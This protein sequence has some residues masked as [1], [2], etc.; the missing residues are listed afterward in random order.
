MNKLI[1][2]G[3]GFDI[4]NGL[5]SK[6]IDFLT[7]YLT[8]CFDSSLN[9]RGNFKELINISANLINQGQNLLKVT[10]CKELAVWLINERNF[11]NRIYSPHFLYKEAMYQFKI[12]TTNSDLFTH[13]LDHQYERNWVDIEMTYYNLLKN[14]LSQF[15]LDGSE[16]KAT[17]EKKLSKINADFEIL[18]QNLHQYLAIISKNASADYNF[19]YSAESTIDSQILID[20]HHI[21][22]IPK[23]DFEDDRYIK[24]KDVTFLNFNYTGLPRSLKGKIYN[25]ID[26]HGSVHYNS[27]IVF[28]F[29]DEID[30]DYLEMEKT[31]NNDFLTYIKSFGYFNNSNYKDLIDLIDSDSYVVY[32][33]GH[34]CGLSDRTLLNMI[35]EHDNCAAIKPY[36]W[37]KDQNNNNYLEITQNISRHFKNKLKMRN[38]VVNKQYCQ[39]LGSQH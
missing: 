19:N 9:N 35:F 18:R 25:H 8:E 30:S 16:N 13:L 7:W 33:W 20:K 31:N 23:E 24:F 4:H 32:I 22:N 27:P 37:E 2:V 10:D 5:P 28:G 11:Q 3:N 17:A 29:G 12:D 36:Y 1:I 21:K 34:S 14:C 6:Y 26:I 38:R 39:P 15:K